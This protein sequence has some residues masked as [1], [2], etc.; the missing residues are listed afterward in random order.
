VVADSP[1]WA[2]Q[3]RLTSATLLARINAHA[4]TEAVRSIRVLT[5]GGTAA[6][7]P[8]VLTVPNNTAPVVPGAAQPRE[9]CADYQR[10]L[11]AHRQAQTDRR[12]AAR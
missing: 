5:P 2:T 6:T 4:G 9:R 7:E 3:L 11:A 1:A 12:P 8:S 10:A